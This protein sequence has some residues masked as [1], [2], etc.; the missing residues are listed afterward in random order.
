MEGLR[1]HSLFLA[2]TGALLVWSSAGTSLQMAC[3]L[4]AIGTQQ[5]LKM[6]LLPIPSIAAYAAAYLL[7]LARR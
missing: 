7:Q 3:L 4:C 6:M 1:C 2:P 5:A